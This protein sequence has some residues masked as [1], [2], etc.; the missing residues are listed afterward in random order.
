MPKNKI[1]AIVS[2]CVVAVAAIILAVLLHSTSGKL[3]LTQAE[4]ATT[5]PR[6]RRLRPPKPMWKRN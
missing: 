2:I 6:Y 3:K 5:K 4:L 1:L